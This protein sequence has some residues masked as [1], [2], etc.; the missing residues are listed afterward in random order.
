MEVKL[1][2][3]VLLKAANILDY[4]AAHPQSKLQ[5]IAIGCQLTASTTLKI[6]DTLLFIHYVEKNAQKEFFLGTKFIRYAQE[7]LQ[8]NTLN[9]VA[10]S[11]L[12]QLQAKIDETIHLGILENN[13][14]VYLDKLEPKNQNI[15]MSSRVGIT[16][17]LYS[18]AMG[19]AVLSNFSDQ[20]LATYLQ[21][22]SPLTAYTENTITDPLQLEEEIQKVKV[23]KVAF[24]D[25]E[26]EKDIFCVGAALLVNGKIQGAFSISLPKYRLTVEKK[27]KMITE[28]LITKE[29]IEKKLGGEI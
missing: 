20:E 27:E 9:E 26:M 10:S 6:L 4:L 8:Q 16:R 24:D 19:K 1:Y 14:I 21:E 3:T 11:F 17:P 22:V 18:S 2:G 23:Q 28:I 12:H 25:E 13:V 29:K 15:T 5:E 7:S